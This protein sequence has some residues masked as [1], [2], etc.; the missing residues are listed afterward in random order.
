MAARA[1]RKSAGISGR[2][3]ASGKTDFAPSSVPHQKRAKLRLERGLAQVL[4]KGDEGVIFVNCDPTQP[5]NLK[6]EFD[7]GAD[8]EKGV[9]HRHGGGGKVLAA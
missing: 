6:K 9:D 7:P 4:L 5:Q 8:R 1:R 3:P 2:L